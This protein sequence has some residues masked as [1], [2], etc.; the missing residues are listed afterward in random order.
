MNSDI[1]IISGHCTM[2][3]LTEMNIYTENVYICCFSQHPMCQKI[4][5]ESSICTLAEDNLAIVYSLVLA[6]PGTVVNLVLAIYKVSQP[7]TAG[8]YCLLSKNIV[9]FLIGVYG[10]LTTAK[11]WAFDKSIIPTPGIGK[12]ALCVFVT[13][14]Q[15]LVVIVYL[16]IVAVQM[17]GLYVSV[18]SLHI[19]NI[20]YMRRSNIVIWI[21]GIALTVTFYTVN[22]VSDIHY[23]TA[24]CSYV[25]G[26]SRLFTTVQIIVLAVFTV[27]SC[28]IV[29]FA[30]I[31]LRLISRS[32]TDL[33]KMG[34]IKKNAAKKMTTNTWNIIRCGAIPIALS[35]PLIELGICSKA[36]TN[37]ESSVYLAFNNYLLQVIGIIDPLLYLLQKIVNKARKYWKG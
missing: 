37:I 11:E 1:N 24:E 6:I 29:L 12:Y 7:K 32:D 25:T 13:N 20:S 4:T 8:K 27:S 17:W 30:V 5:S 36:I 35:V 22:I 21:V 23:I 18:S 16:P 3:I 33:S 14:L 9:G 10:F 28:F 19:V 2:E 34:F 26:T 15:C 31:A